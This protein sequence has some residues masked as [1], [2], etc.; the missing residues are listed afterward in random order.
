MCHPIPLSHVDV[1]LELCENGVRIRA[2]AT[3][4]AVTGVEMEAMTAASIAALTVYDMCK[5]LD[6]GIEIREVVLKSKSGG[7]SGR[8]QRPAKALPK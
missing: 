6:K 1:H 5:A 7:K 2:T 4:T 8:Y 3:T